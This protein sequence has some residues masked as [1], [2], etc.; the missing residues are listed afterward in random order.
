M[1]LNL[2]SLRG[3]EAFL[4]AAEAGSMRAAAHALNLTVSAVSYRIQVLENELGVLLFSR[5][6]PVLRLTEAGKHYR[7]EILPGLR[8]MMLATSRIRQ[9]ADGNK[10]RVATVP[11]FYSTWVMPR[12]TGFL[13]RH[14]HTRIELLSLETREAEDAD[15]TIQPVYSLHAKAGEIRLC[16]WQGTSICHPDLV[17][18]YDLRE[19]R[20]L[21]AAP[22][23]DLHTPLDLWE[24][25]FAVAGLSYAMN[26][27]RVLVDSQ[28]LM[29]DAVMQ[30]V[31][32]AMATTFFSQTYLK[33][34]LVRP[35][36]LACS[37]P[38]GMFIS[39]AKP[40]ENAILGDFRAWLIE[41]VALSSPH[42]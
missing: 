32:V 18:K 12:L 21:L 3:L 35:F 26:Q 8:G 33:A 23:I 6:G 22:L 36:P 10:I 38:G 16:G 2:P 1:R 20:D 5:N 30:K 24:N 28:A 15:L 9:T 42:A 34:G 11:L 17:K 4:A 41:E 31:G 37:F 29:Y 25:W 19:P 40:S 14:P 39:A 27:N 13:E 7:R